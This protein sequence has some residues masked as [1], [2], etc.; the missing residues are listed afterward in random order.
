M[1]TGRFMASGWDKTWTIELECT[2]TLGVD[3]ASSKIKKRRI[4]DYEKEYEPM[5]E[6]AE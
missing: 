2:E 5:L 1:K 3:R 4:F 6:S